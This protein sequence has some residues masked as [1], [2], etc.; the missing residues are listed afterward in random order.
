MNEKKIPFCRKELKASA[1]VFTFNDGQTREVDYD[2]LPAEIQKQLGLHGLSQKLG[3]SYASADGDVGFALGRLDTVA[4]NLQEGNWAAARTSEGGLSPKNILC[5]AVAEIRGVTPEAIAA[6]FAS[7]D[8]EVIK[9]VRAHPHVKAKM[10]ELKAKAAQ[11]TAD[12]TGELE[13]GL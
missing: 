11:E 4:T 1:I 12:K 2:T 3:D 5:R 9:K 6:H 8:E 13:L 7:A 10:L